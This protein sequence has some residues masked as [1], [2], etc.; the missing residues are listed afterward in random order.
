MV[1]LVRHGKVLTLRQPVTLVLLRLRCLEHILGKLV[2]LGLYGLISAGQHLAPGLIYRC[3]LALKRGQALPVGLR[4]LAL[5]GGL[6]VGLRLLALNGG[7]PV[8]LRLLALNGGLPV[9]LRLLALNGGLP[10]GL[11]LLALNGGLPVGLR[12]LTLKGSA[13]GR[14]ALRLLPALRCPFVQR[15]LLSVLIRLLRFVEARRGSIEILLLDRLLALA[16]RRAGL[17]P[18]CRRELL[19]FRL[20]AA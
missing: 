6:P 4:L 14:H 5:N 12:L 2:G 18:Q 7:L 1:N 20:C 17:G 11:R 13:G 9:G 19:G 3:P 16:L 10:V 8:G 15:D